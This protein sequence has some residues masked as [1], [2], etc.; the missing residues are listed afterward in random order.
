MYNISELNE[1]TPEQL[2]EVAKTMGLKKT[3][4]NSTEELVYR[5]ID[6]QAEIGASASVAER[7]KKNRRQEK[8]SVPSEGD[9]APKNRGRK[10]KEE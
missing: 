4:K 10:K 1:M 2:T 8:K 6:H 9:A 3:D 5:I 7:E